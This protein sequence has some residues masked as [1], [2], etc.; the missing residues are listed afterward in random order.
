MA[1]RDTV[2]LALKLAEAFYE[3]EL[4]DLPEYSLA[5][6][7]T[8]LID[9]FACIHAATED[10][11]REALDIATS[12]GDG[13]GPCHQLASGQTLA[14]AA[15]AIVNGALLRSLDLMDVYA[16][17]DVSHPGEIVPVVIAAAEAM[18]ANGRLVLETLAAAFSLHVSLSEV[19]PVH[20]HGLHHTGHAAI[21]A[22]LAIARV[23]GL[24][25][26]Q[27]A[28]ALN[29]GSSRLLMPEGFSRGHVT[30]LKT[31][32]Y[33]LQAKSA[34]DAV[35]MVQKGL[36][37]SNTMLEVMIALWGRLAGEPAELDRILTLP[38]HEG[39]DKIWLKRFPAQYALQPL[40]SAAIEF[41]QS[42]PA[43]HASIAEI[44]V[45]ASQRTVDRCA[46]SA[47]YRL[48]SA[49]A[50]DHSLPFC[51]A[52]A[53]ID[54][55]LDVLSLSSQRWLDADVL[56]LMA[57]IKV[58]PLDNECG[59]AVGRQSVRIALHDG[60]QIDL[61]PTYPPATMDWRGVAEEKLRI[62]ALP[63]AS[64]DAIVSFAENLEAVHDL[65]AEIARLVS[66]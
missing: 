17:A 34:F 44:V 58:K 63:H 49:E 15:A 21:V 16:G 66:G 61:I 7:K 53:L 32:A 5:H 36:Q 54:T 59:Y 23:S 24:S 18:Q 26:E 4:D 39:I 45:G 13:S 56:S 30:N 29:L 3:V 40:I 1:D 8:L 33:A 60:K 42:R 43:I 55:R 27:A 2:P 37:G 57:K 65:R 28:A 41:S 50:A 38:P 14:P 9:V 64:P 51:F 19:V 12:D 20:R 6:V 62:Y 10:L 35:A 22:P 25:A 31:Y 47:K 11:A 46:D 48:T 52:A